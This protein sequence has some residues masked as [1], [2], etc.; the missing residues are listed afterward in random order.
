MKFQWLLNGSAP[1]F[2]YLSLSGISKQPVC[3]N[4]IFQFLAFSVLPSMWPHNRLMGF[5]ILSS[6][7]TPYRQEKGKHCT[8]FKEGRK[9]DPRNFLSA[10]PHCLGRWW[11]TS[12]SSAKAYGGQGGIWDSQ[13][14]FTKGKSCLTSPVTFYN[15]VTASGDREE[16]V[17][18]FSLWM[19]HRFD[20]TPSLET[21]KVRL[22][23]DRSHLL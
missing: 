14:S 12:L 6:Y 16:T 2:L 20:L 8:S 15:G 1:W 7:I 13:H 17:E 23:G 11:N 5:T 10:F 9:E 19:W 22:D 21:F 18:V 3:W 4:L